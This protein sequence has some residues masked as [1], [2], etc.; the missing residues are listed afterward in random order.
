M[1]RC[2]EDAVDRAKLGDFPGVHDGDAIGDLGDHAHIMGDEN[3]RRAQLIAYPR[4]FLQ[5]LPLCDHIKR[6]RQFRR[7]RLELDAC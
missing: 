4:Q 5:D 7:R 3:D 2:L 1:K 6:G